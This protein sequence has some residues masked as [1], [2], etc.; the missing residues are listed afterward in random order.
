MGKK[1]MLSMA[2]LPVMLSRRMLPGLLLIMSL[3]WA[4]QTGQA[5]GTHCTRAG[6]WGSL[7]VVGQRTASKEP[8]EAVLGLS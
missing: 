5:V 1:Q 2:L 6:A 8:T 3:P 7:C 4:S